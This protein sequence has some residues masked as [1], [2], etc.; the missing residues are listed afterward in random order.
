M[1]RGIAISVAMMAFI[2]T[3][4][5]ALKSFA[6]DDQPKLIDGPLSYRRIYVPANDPATWPRGQDKFLP[7]ES[8]DFNAWV[9]A[10]NRT[11][12]SNAIEG[13]DVAEYTGSLDEDGRLTGHGR[14]DFATYSGEPTFIRLLQPS[15]VITNARW[16]GTEKQPAQFGVW[17]KGAGVPNAW[18]LLIATSGSV[19]FDWYVQGRQQ[20][21]SL[22]IPWRVP[23]ATTTRV[24][25]DLPSGQQPAITGAVILESTPIGSTSE[26]TAKSRR[27]WKLAVPASADA[28]LQ[29]ISPESSKNASVEQ[30]SLQ[31]T[32]N[33]QLQRRGL[34]VAAAWSLDFRGFQQDDVTVPLPNGVELT[35][36]T[37]DGHAVNW[38]V[39]HGGSPSDAKATI[40]LPANSDTSVYQIELAAWQPL[41]VDRPWQLPLL[42]PESVFWSAGQLN[43]E[44][45]RDLELRNV[46]TTDC[47]QQPV[48]ASADDVTASQSLSFA[49]YSPSATLEVRISRHDPEAA[50]RMC[51]SLALADPD[52]TGKLA[53][54]WNVSQSSLYKFSG[55]LSPGWNIEAV[56]TIPSDA[57]AE[58]FIDRSDQR[59]TLEIQ[60]THPAGPGHPVTVIV[61][62]RLQRTNLTEPLTADSLRVV[63][64]SNSRVLQHLV[65]FQSTEPFVAETVGELPTVPHNLIGDRERALFEINANEHQVFDLTRAGKS[66]GLRLDLRRAE[67]TADVELDSNFANNE[68]RQSWRVSARPTANAIDRILVYATAS[69][70]DNV[71]WVE[72]FTNNPVVAERIPQGDSRRKAL[73]KDGEVWLLRLSQPTS[74]LV[75]LGITTTC[76]LNKRISLALLSLPNALEQHGSVYIHGPTG[77]APLIESKALVPI[78]VSATDANA[79]ATDYGRAVRAAFRYAPSECLDNNRT[80]SLSIAPPAGN[81]T[82]PFVVRNLNLESFFWPNGKAQHCATYDLVS[83]GATEFRPRLPSDAKLNAIIVNHQLLDTAQSMPAASV[84]PIPISAASR[85]TN[86]QIYFETHQPPLGSIS[87]LAAPAVLHDLPVLE[88]E[89]N[90]WLPQGFEIQD[91]ARNSSTWRQRIFGPLARSGVLPPFN[92]LRFADPPS[93]LSSDAS[94]KSLPEPLPTSAVHPL[95]S[96]VTAPA[97]LEPAGIASEK[98]SLRTLQ[99]AVAPSDPVAECIGWH[100]VHQTNFADGTPAPM[101]VT[102]PAVL[103]AWELVALF[104]SFILASRS[105]IQGRW[106]FVASAL[107]A[108][109]ALMLPEAAA[110][111]AT[112]ALWGFVI[113]ALANLSGARSSLEKSSFSTVARS[114]I[115]SGISIFFAVHAQSAIAAPD[116]S[117][118]PKLSSEPSSAERVLIPVDADKKV[119]GSKYF[120]GERFLHNLLERQTTQHAGD[121]TWLLRD[122]S[123]VGELSDTRDT[124]EITVGRWSLAFSIETLA[125]DTTISLPLIKDEA[126]WQTSAMLDGVPIPIVWRE[127]GRECAVEVAQ[128]GRYTLALFCTPRS[129]DT[130][131]RRRISLSIP[132]LASANIQLHTPAL[133]TGVA[134]TDAIV[135]P[136]TKDA[137]RTISGELVQSHQIVV[138]WPRLKEKNSASQGLNV[139]ELKWLRV[140]PNGT[141]LETK[142]ILEGG[143]RRPESL[144]V[145]YD[146]RWTPI[147][148]LKAAASDQAGEAV[149]GLRT[150]SIPLG[151]SDSD[152]QEVAVRWKL[153][154]APAIGLI[155]LPPVYLASPSVMQRWL[156][157]SVDSNLDCTLADNNTSAATANEFMTRWGSV[158]DAPAVTTVVANFE[159]DRVWT[160]AV[161]PRD[162]ES[163]F[164]EILHVAI[165]LQ[166]FRIVYEANVVPANADRFGLRLVVPAKLTID[167]ITVAEADRQISTRW[168][169]DSEDHVNVFFTSATRSDYRLTLSGTLPSGV[170]TP[171]RLP[172]VSA[173]AATSATQVQLYRD[174][175]VEVKLQHFPAV[176][177]AKTVSVELPPIQWL[178]RPLG[179]FRLDDGEIQRAQVT[180]SRSQVPLA[181]DMLTSI[182]HEGG[183]WWATLTTHLTSG[184]NLD[185]FRLRLP[186]A[187]VGPFEVESSVPESKEIITSSDG[188]QNLGIRFNLT[189]AQNGVVDLKIRSPLAVPSGSAVVVPTITTMSQLAGRRYIGVPTALENEPLMWSDVGVQ[190]A[191]VPKQLMQGISGPQARYE[192]VKEPILVASR[193]HAAKEPAPRV[194]LVDTSVGLGNNGAQTIISSFVISPDGISECLIQLPTDHQLL[195]AELDG[196]AA[197]ITPVA[198][199]KW[200]VVLSTTQLPQVLEIVSRVEPKHSSDQLRELTRVALLVGGKPLPVEVSLWSISEPAGSDR[201]A[202][203]GA[204]PVSAIDQAVLR[205]D[206]LVSIAES[207]SATAAEAP[208]PDGANW[209]RPW[210]ARLKAVH[211]QSSQLVG[212]PTGT[213]SVARLPRSSEEQFSQI[214]NRFEKWLEEST[215]LFGNSDNTSATLASE[216]ATAKDDSR[217]QNIA[218]YASQ[219]SGEKLLVQT[220]RPGSTS[221]RA[222]MA[223]AIVVILFAGLWLSKM[224]AASDFLHRF[225]YLAGVL[226]GIGYWAWLSPSWFGLVLAAASACL[227]L[228]FSWPGR[229]LR[230]EAST[231]LPSTRTS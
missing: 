165:G 117:P 133:L 86:I 73:P 84:V 142:Y 39:D 32:V 120:V 225:P 131:D 115:A 92:P 196:R 51:S 145:K 169:R 28:T 38:R 78:P 12:K 209:F 210:A 162:V 136:T 161:R 43:V 207:A 1:F 91:E 72:R 50:I 128:P 186:P 24:T 63:R 95:S 215:D 222:I 83:D 170:D 123:Y 5:C 122:A 124:S 218:Y 82:A 141:E 107:A 36:V 75:E 214:S 179:A 195:S 230:P 62:G 10:A 229:F 182:S 219:G 118:V 213:A 58:W 81:G 150:L 180:V 221:L 69:L 14:W 202:V 29:I 3:A 30:P 34:N 199:S 174:D 9:A 217:D 88:H 205:F 152:R 206:R 147:T 190:P 65:S 134:V 68:L 177:D 193:P 192:I 204:S 183:G 125:R 59:R 60:L 119:V 187:C 132:E 46:S 167:N 121:H 16:K 168:V 201:I 189:V 172:R 216:L 71:H 144:S 19:E 129:A 176:A 45:S 64:W 148:R 97:N 220:V 203:V 200:R 26:K 80:P 18:G 102:R 41:T 111:L 127:E 23:N 20:N 108:V 47:A 90:V 96:T 198:N 56:E 99:G 116:S 143:N 113:A 181:G 76:P 7:I 49:A 212:Q 135:V 37:A 224:P 188:A 13:I 54:E 4:S 228:R 156:A 194:R 8:S 85:H 137:P 55:E 11:T 104:V 21:N 61:N 158:A 178:V 155:R 27:C 48:G 103:S 77:N 33:Y 171:I 25:L 100:K 79:A 31:E 151:A 130:G 166:T 175:D 112:G 74:K 101:I 126:V 52:V 110:P 57:L 139:A 109:L 223:A 197:L 211:Q 149:G 98:A 15:I 146:P 208:Q 17:G 53:T 227:A 140:G 184:G 6:A 87:T 157:I 93:I 231:V 154:G 138:D 160:L 42:H 2:A 191:T 70:G 159:A 106:L 153:E 105:S 44:V 89:W 164:R 66:A 226:L 173:S 67:Y 185:I 114:T 22:E 94:E 40:S 35:S 163:A